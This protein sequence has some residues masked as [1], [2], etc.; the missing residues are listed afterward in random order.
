MSNVMIL[1][2]SFPLRKYKFNV[3]VYLI[4]SYIVTVKSIL[5]GDL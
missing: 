5:F 4:I 2:N 3:Q 1:A